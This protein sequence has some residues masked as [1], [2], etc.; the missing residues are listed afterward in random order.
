MKQTPNT[1]SNTEARATKTTRTTITTAIATQSSTDNYHNLPD[2]VARDVTL[3][4]PALR[5]Y[6]ILLSM[7]DIQTGETAPIYIH[8]LAEK[9]NRCERTM[10][11]WLA[12]LINRGF[13]ERVF[14]KD[15]DNLKHNLSSYF[16]ITHVRD[17][18]CCGKDKG[19]VR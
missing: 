9:F 16:I 7:S 12:E 14:R 18:N 10:Q 8:Q 1:K 19:K 4:A 13:I 17:A 11:K 5:L 6:A 15:K 3:P 2:V